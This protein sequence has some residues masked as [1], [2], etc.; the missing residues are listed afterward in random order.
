MKTV[1]M[2]PQLMIENI[3]PDGSIA[4]SYVRVNSEYTV[5]QQAEGDIQIRTPN[6]ANE[7]CNGCT[8]EA[9]SCADLFD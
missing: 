1:Y 4:A 7:I 8:F 3:I 6:L 9:N 5:C 2:K